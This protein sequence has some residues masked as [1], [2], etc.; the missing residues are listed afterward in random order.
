[1]MPRHESQIVVYVH[2]TTVGASVAPHI[3][4]PSTS[5]RIAT[6]HAFFL[7]PVFLPAF[8]VVSGSATSSA[9]PST[10]CLGETGPLNQGIQAGRKALRIC[11]I[12]DVKVHMKRPRGF[13]KRPRGFK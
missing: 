2:H 8:L 7:A 10:S 5:S 3:S 12:N 6:L 1:M 9:E 11:Y 4:A 13:K